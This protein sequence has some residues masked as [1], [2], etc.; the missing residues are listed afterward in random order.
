MPQRV[1]LHKSIEKISF[2]RWNAIIQIIF[3]N[4]SKVCDVRYIFYGVKFLEQVF[5]FFC[6]VLVS[7]SL[8]QASDTKFLDFGWNWE[9]EGWCMLDV[10]RGHHFERASHRMKHTGEQNLKLGQ[11]RR[12]PPHDIIWTL[13]CILSEPHHPRLSSY[14]NNWITIFVY[15]SLRQVSVTCIWKESE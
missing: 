15:T 11:E 5:L 4:C 12:N 9:P 1:S 8:R 14:V 3:A 2:Q 6:L 7:W 10:I 13:G